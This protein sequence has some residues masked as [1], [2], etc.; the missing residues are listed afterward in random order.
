MASS[1][2]GTGPGRGGGEMDGGG[3]CE[4]VGEAPALEGVPD[5]GGNGGIVDRIE[6]NG[7]ESRV[8]LGREPGS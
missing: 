1:R 4:N 8:A 7:D 6:G 3:C 2:T 5:A